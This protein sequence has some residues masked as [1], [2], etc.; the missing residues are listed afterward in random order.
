MKRTIRYSVII[1][2]AA[3]AGCASQSNDSRPCLCRGGT[4]NVFA[5]LS[6]RDDPFG[7][8]RLAQRVSTAYQQMVSSWTNDYLLDCYLDRD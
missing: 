6:L 4:P 3:A 8:D 7:A 5:D 2:V 1:L